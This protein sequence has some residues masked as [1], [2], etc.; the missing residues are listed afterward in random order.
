MVQFV[1]PAVQPKQQPMPLSVADKQA[2]QAK[3]RLAAKTF[4]DD[5]WN[6]DEYSIC[7]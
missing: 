4:M 3:Q 5:E 2:L 7:A 1:G 6:R